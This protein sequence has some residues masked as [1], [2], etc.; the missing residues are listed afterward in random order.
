MLEHDAARDGEEIGARFPDGVDASQGGEPGVGLLND[1]ILIDHRQ[2]RVTQPTADVAFMR[3]DAGGDPRNP[4]RHNP[5]QSK[6]AG[7]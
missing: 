1:V 2:R 5:L 6:K 3:R 7:L 4:V